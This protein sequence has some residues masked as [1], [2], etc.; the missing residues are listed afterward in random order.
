M[1]LGLGSASER[2]GLSLNGS[3][4]E[5]WSFISAA[6]AAAAAEGQYFLLPRGADVGQAPPWLHWQPGED[7]EDARCPATLCPRRSS[8]RN[9]F[10]FEV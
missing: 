2:S 7:A 10:G 6:A 4:K 8:H 9:N 3:I 5:G 1:G